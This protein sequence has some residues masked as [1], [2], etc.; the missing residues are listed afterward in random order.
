VGVAA[1]VPRRHPSIERTEISR[2]AT[3]S[4][5]SRERKA[6]RSK[7]ETTRATLARE[8]LI[9]ERQALKRKQKRAVAAAARDAQP[10][11]SDGRSSETV[12]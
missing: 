3:G 5:L 4:D 9:Q 10:G 7:R 6:L 2:R 1:F 12:G 8:R 11:E